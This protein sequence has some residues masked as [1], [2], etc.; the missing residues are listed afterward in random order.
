MER[1]VPPLYIVLILITFVVLASVMGYFAA[2]SNSKRM[3][4]ITGAANQRMSK[5]SIG[6]Q[7]A[8]L[9]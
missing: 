9:T 6:P 7:N 5:R 2:R 4:E 8:Y 1:Y 3:K